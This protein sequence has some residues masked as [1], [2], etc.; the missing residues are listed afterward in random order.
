MRLFCSVLV[1]LWLGPGLTGQT[2]PEPGTTRV[3]PYRID[4]WESDEGL[5]GNSVI[6]MTQSE[7]GYLWLGTNYGLSRFDGIRFTSYDE[8]TTPGLSSRPIV[9]LM[10]DSRQNLWLAM[11]TTEVCLVEEGRVVPL[12]LEHTGGE[13]RLSALCED[14]K[15]AVWMLTSEGKLSRRFEGRIDRWVIPEAVYSSRRALVADLEG[16]LRLGTDNGLFTLDLDGP[17]DSNTLP[18]VR[19]LDLE[20]FD[21]LLASRKGGYWL[22]ANGRIRRWRAG[23]FD[24][25]WEEYPWGQA[26]VATACED[27]QGNLVVGTLGAGVYWFD[28]EGNATHLSAAQGLS[29]DYILSLHVDREEN[30]WV[31]TDGGGLNRVKRQAFQPVAD[32]TGLVVQTVSSDRDGGVWIGVN[33]I[34][35]DPSGAGYWKDGRWQWY[36]P[37]EGL[38]YASVRSILVDREQRVW[39][40]TWGAGLYQFQEGRFRRVTLPTRVDPRIQVIYQDRSGSLWLGTQRGLVEWSPGGE[41]RVYLPEDG[42]SEGAIRAIADDPDGGLWIGTARGGLNRFRDG[43]F[44]PVHQED[45]LPG[46]EIA[47]LHVDSESVLWVGTAGSGLGRFDGKRW[48]RYTTS[49]GLISN[50]LGY[51]AEDEG[52]ALWIGS[53]AGLMR[54]SKRVLNDFANGLTASTPCRAYSRL[55]GL[56]A[57]ECMGFQP[58]AG[59]TPDGR[60]WFPTINGLV[61][62]DPSL[63]RLNTQPPPVVI[64]TVLIDGQ[65]AHASGLLARLPAEVI[66]P[67][68]RE[69]LEIQYT[70]LN[71]AA[72]DRARFNYRLKG[73]E[74]DWTEAGST[75]IAR[76]S[77]LP[78]GAYE[79]EVIASNEDG[80]WNEAGRS[81]SITVVPPFWRTWWF[82]GACF[83]GFLGMTVGSVH[84]TSTQRWR[85][86]VERLH[87][88][89]LVERERA[90]IARDIHD[91][92]GASLTQVALLGELVESDKDFPDEVEVHARQISQTARE[93][94][95][96][97]DEIVWTVNPSNDTLEG[98]V[99]YICKNAQDYVAVAGLRYRLDVPPH[100]PE[101]PISPEVRHNVFLASKEA[102]TNVVR[103][104]HASSV[105]LGLTLAPDRFTLEIRDDGSGLGGMDKERAGRRNGL[106][107]MRKR[108]E[109]IGGAFA[110]ESLENGGTEVRLSVPILVET[111]SGANTPR[112]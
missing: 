4:V 103:H 88:K 87:Q 45:G 107:N 94:T 101:V 75:R 1:A 3:V 43:G 53:N 24:V 76:Y 39:A 20:G 92:L 47:S 59:K 46:E 33:R 57:L 40:G 110:M 30:L 85:R 15:G 41:W 62:V 77:K 68:G 27:L 109:D 32:T 28:A 34:G 16:S 71:L 100:L 74:S 89:E 42:L 8:S 79:F 72:P 84:Y 51:I 90:R 80:V 66:M 60:L 67:A 63:I 49:Q 17:L 61:A 82:L 105:H 111:G 25:D 99:N 7:D 2:V 12:E 50:I 14:K 97:L 54:V 93:T 44:T 108:M 78:P 96:V 37:R 55:D 22:L 83:I 81:L 48:T 86:Q 65:R 19:T 95:L 91:Q 69:R 18:L 26:V 6:S 21:H 52:G 29:Y 112:S 38:A 36:G 98:L 64:E 10:E 56:P 70:S 58:G 104:A 73:H 23:A 102:I 9:R 35:S 31:G 5:P 13:V 106:G 11:G